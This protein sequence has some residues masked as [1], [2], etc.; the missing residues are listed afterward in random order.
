VVALRHGN[1]HGILDVPTCLAHRVGAVAQRR[2]RRADV[3]E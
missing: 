1:D 2:T 3:V